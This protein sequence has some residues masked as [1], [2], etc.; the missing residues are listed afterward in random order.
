[1]DVLKDRSYALRGITNGIDYDEFNPKT[2]K[3][4][5]QNYDINSIENKVINKTQLQKELGLTVD[6]NIP[7]IAMVTRLTHQKGID[8]LVNISDRLLQQN[9]QLVSFRNW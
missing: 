1:M 5:K 2:D 4:I 9:V 8:L 7:M 6:E 3:F